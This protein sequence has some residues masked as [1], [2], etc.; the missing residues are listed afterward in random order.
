MLQRYGLIVLMLA[1][2]GLQISGCA[3]SKTSFI[4]PNM[5]FGSVQRCAVFPF[6][7]LT[8]DG[9]ADDKLY[10]IFMME[11]LAEGAFEVLSRGEVLGAMPGLNL[12]I[13]MS[14]T[15]EQIVSLGEKLS[16]DAI[17]FGS[18]EEFGLSKG[19][20]SR[21]SE[22]TAVFSMA[23]TQTGIV[24]WRAQIHVEGSSIWRKLFGGGSRSLHDVSRD[25]VRQALQTLL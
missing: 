16:V 18:I 13:G 24:I 9:F 7:N 11:L 5:D 20:G 1:G 12:T 25:A 21:V 17:F 23:E 8:S 22:V 14:L 6:Q 10:S 2:L 4:H 15:Q 3:S 19:S